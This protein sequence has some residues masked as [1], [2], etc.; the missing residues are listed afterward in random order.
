M[1]MLEISQMPHPS[2][3]SLEKG[4]LGMEQKGQPALFLK[5]IGPFCRCDVL[6]GG[7]FSTWRIMHLGE[8]HAAE[9]GSCDSVA[10]SRSS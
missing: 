9:A 7:L 6:I 10:P 5:E 1:A 8:V 3:D 4:I 2:P